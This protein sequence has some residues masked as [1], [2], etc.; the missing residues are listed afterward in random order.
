[1]PIILPALSALP[2][3]LVGVRA[4]FNAV[5]QNSTRAT[6]RIFW[7]LKASENFDENSENLSKV[8]LPNIPTAFVLHLV[9]MEGEPISVA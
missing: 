8:L 1:M 3:L 2:P 6:V 4:T 7:K 9:P 5:V